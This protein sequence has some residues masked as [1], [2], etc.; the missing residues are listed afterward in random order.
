MKYLVRGGLVTRV[1]LLMG[2]LPLSPVHMFQDVSLAKR[3]KKLK[4]ELSPPS[5]RS[6][7]SL[8]NTCCYQYHK[9]VGETGWNLNMGVSI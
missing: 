5:I 9:G 8:P 7:H 6:R 1:P 3:N 4:L 2:S